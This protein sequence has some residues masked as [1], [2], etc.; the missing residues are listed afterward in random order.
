MHHLM[1]EASDRFGA[2]RGVQ[3]REDSRVLGPALR[4]GVLDSW[5]AGDQVRRGFL[6]GRA[7]RADPELPGQGQR[8]Q[9]GPQ[10]GAELG[11]TEIEPPS[12]RAVKDLWRA[13]EAAPSHPRRAW[14]GC[15]RREED[16]P[17]A[18]NQAVPGVG[19]PKAPGAGNAGGTQPSAE[20]PE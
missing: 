20:Q 8:A 18:A 16:L 13:A 17:R 14:V 9:K 19:A 7:E 12:Q 4:P 10:I 15:P 11:L 1:E 5:A 3:G 6:P 2:Q